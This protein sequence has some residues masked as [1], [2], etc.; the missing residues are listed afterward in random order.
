MWRRPSPTTKMWWPLLTEMARKRRSPKC[1]AHSSSNRQSAATYEGKGERANRKIETYDD[2][3]DWAAAAAEVERRRRRRICIWM[4]TRET[5]LAGC[6]WSLAKLGGQQQ[7]Q[8]LWLITAYRG[9][10]AKMN[11]CV[12]IVLQWTVCVCV[13][14]CSPIR[15][16]K[17]RW[18]CCSD[19]G[20]SLTDC[21][22]SL[23]QQQHQHQQTFE[24]CWLSPPP[25]FSKL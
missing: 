24:I 2:A 12:S 11:V 21:I 25:S 7:Q 3:N 8:P 13:C 22:C 15:A 18:S 5:E 16:Q 23:G 9:F 19:A 1:D 4:D 17:Q 6:G 14:G 10:C 20:R